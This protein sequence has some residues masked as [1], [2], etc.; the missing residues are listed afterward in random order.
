MIVLAALYVVRILLSALA[1]NFGLIPG[2]LLG[3]TILSPRGL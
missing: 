3:L 1:A 2:S